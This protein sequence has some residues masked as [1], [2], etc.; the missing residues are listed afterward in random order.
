MPTKEESGNPAPSLQT[1]MQMKAKFAQAQGQEEQL[2]GAIRE[3]L[4]A[5]PAQDNTQRTD[6]GALLGAQATQ[7]DELGPENAVLGSIIGSVFSRAF[8]EQRSGKTDQDTKFALIL[9]GMSSTSDGEPTLSFEDGTELSIPIDLEQEVPRIQPDVLSGTRTRKL[10]ELD[11]THPFSNK[12]VK[13]VA[14]LA[15]HIVRNLYGYKEQKD[16]KVLEMVTTALTE[17]LLSEGVPYEAS[18]QRVEELKGKLKIS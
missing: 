17:A 1:A 7:K 8:A 4:D 11:N 14:P 6:I 16:A 3:R 18:S 13:K 9:K 12:M 10:S 5:L 15:A 2:P